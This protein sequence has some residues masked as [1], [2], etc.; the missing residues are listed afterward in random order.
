MTRDWYK[1]MELFRESFFRSL[2]GK[3]E[4]ELK[5]L[6]KDDSLKEVYDQLSD[7]EYVTDRFQEFDGYEYKKAFSELKSCRR[8]ILGRRWM[9]WGASV[10]AVLVVVVIFFIDGRRDEDMLKAPLAK[11]QIIA[12]GSRLAVLKMADGRTV[13]IGKQPLEITDG[14]GNVVKYEEGSLSY[15]TD[16]ALEQEIYNEL[17]VPIG[18][19]CH[20]RLDDGTE[21]WLNADSRLK[22][23]VTFTGTQRKVMLSG[24][25]YF[26]VKKDSRLFIVSMEEGDV[27]VLGTSF[28]VS[29]YQGQTGY[30]TLVSGSVRFTS[31]FAESVVLNPG[32]QAVIRTSGELEKRTVDVE[33]YVGWKDG[34]FVFKNRTLGTIMEV[35][36]RWYGVKTVFRDENLRELEYTG[37]LERYNSINTFLQL[38][39]RLK[40]VRYEIEGNMIVLFR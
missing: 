35:L 9:L 29:A 28:G 20:L 6:L 7:E 5:E 4:E 27:V 37:S 1:I 2:S 33:E 3:K 8:R 15:T 13:E 24:E 14:K 11:E 23:P 34:V 26:N 17:E 12:P 16:I 25:A 18:G 32:E 19:E 31:K 38:L 21:V 40:E 36:D 30:T 39:E 22:F 10:V